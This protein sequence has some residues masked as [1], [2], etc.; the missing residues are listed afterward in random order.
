MFE[1]PVLLV[2][3][4]AMVYAAAMDLFTMTIPNRISLA[5]VAGFFAAAVLAGLGWFEI[6]KH[7]G[8]GLAVLAVAIGLFSQ[9]WI[10]GGDAKLLAAAALW[11]GLDH[12]LDYVIMSTLLGGLLTLAILT[13]RSTVP[14]VFI[15][16]R[17][18]LERLHDKKG[19][20][21]YGIA[22]GA[23]GL[24][25]YPQSQIFQAFAA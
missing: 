9:G 21:P 25:L 14:D 18:W 23:A 8:V 13:F 22:L 24:W 12:L 5:L 16:G 19:G 4:I 10:G 7:A 6:V 2:F 17:E 3:P 20:V 15:A 1:Y 11:F